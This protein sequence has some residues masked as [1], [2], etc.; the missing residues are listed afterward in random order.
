MTGKLRHSL[1]LE[2]ANMPQEAA[3]VKMLSTPEEW[4]EGAY[5]YA[6]GVE[7]EDVDEL[8]NKTW[9]PLDVWLKSQDIRRPGEG[10]KPAIALEGYLASEVDKVRVLS[11]R[12]TCT[13]RTH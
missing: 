3:A 8:G 2:L 4:T 9:R 11:L 10:G 12:L 7:V 5:Q 1:N 6:V 13:L